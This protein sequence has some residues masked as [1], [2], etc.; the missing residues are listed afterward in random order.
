[1]CDEKI[2]IPATTLSHGECGLFYWFI[3]DYVNDK[4]YWGLTG[5]RGWKRK[6][7]QLEEEKKN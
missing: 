7:V 6:L 4:R 1:M 2:I 5:K 3:E